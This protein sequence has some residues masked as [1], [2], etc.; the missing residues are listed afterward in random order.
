MQPISDMTDDDFMKLQVLYANEP[1][2][3]P[4]CSLEDTRHLLSDIVLDAPS[5]VSDDVRQLLQGS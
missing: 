3:C 2:I 5:L 1:P 4:I